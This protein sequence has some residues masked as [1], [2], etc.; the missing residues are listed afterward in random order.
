MSQTVIELESDG[1]PKHFVATA[2]MVRDDRILLTH[3]KKIGLWL[4]PGGHIETREDPVTALR[5]EIREETG[6]EIEI[7]SDS[8]DPGA[9]DEIVQVLPL[10]HHIQVER[11]ADGPHDH[12]DLVYLCRVRP[13]Q[14]QGNEESLGLRWFSREDLASTDIVENVRYFARQAIDEVTRREG[15]DHR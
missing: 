3:H 1:L 5:R 14:A 11:I 10:P 9:S 4:P 15:R 7:L 2:L 8:V 12:I 6:L 13:G